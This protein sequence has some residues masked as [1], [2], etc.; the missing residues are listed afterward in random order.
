MKAVVA[1]MLFAGHDYVAGQRIVINLSGYDWKLTLDPDAEW[2]KDKLYA[3][4]V[5]I[6]TLPVNLPVGGWKALEKHKGV[7]VHL[8]ATVEQYFWGYNGETFGVTGN[9]IGVS[10]FVT[11]VVIPDEMK[12][13]RIALHTESVRLRAEIFV[14]GQLA[15][16]DLVSGTPFET[17]ITSFVQ[18]G[19][20]NKIAYRITDPNGNFNWKD[21]QVYAWGDYWMNPTHGFGGITG[22]V[23]LVATDRIYVDDVFVKNKPKVDEIDTQIT[24]MNLTGNPVSGKL[25]IRINEA[26][27]A[28]KTVYAKEVN[29]S[30]NPG[31]NQQTVTVR[32]PNAKLWSVE[33]PNLYILDASWKSAEAADTYQQQFGFRWF[34]VRDNKGDK[35]YYLNGKRIVLLSAI[36][37]GFWP[38]NGIAPS[39]ELAKKQVAAAK[40]LGM[41][42]LNF[43]RAIGQRK[44]LNAAD[45]AGLLYWQE[46]G[47]NSYP[48]NRF[49]AQDTLGKM[50]TD[51]YFATRT[52]KLLRMIKRDRSHPSLIIY[53]MHNERGAPPQ[54]QDYAQMRA[55]HRLDETR[56][57]IYNSCNGENPMDRPDAKFKTHLMPYDT[58]FR[59]YGWYDRHHAGG[60]GV[61]H[62]NLYNSPINYLRYTN[63]KDE[64]VFWGEDG[65]IGTPPRLQLIRDEILKSG[66]TTGWEAADY[67]HWYDAYN[68]FLKT[69]GFDNAFPDVD[70]LTTA[71]GNVSYY[72]QGRIIENIRINNINDGYAINGWESMKWENHSGI[73][74]NY[75]NLKGNP[76]LI[77]RYNRPLYVAVKTNWKVL[78]AGDT[79]T[80]DFFI[81]NEKDVKGKYMLR[82][83]LTDKDDQKITTAE[84]P[85]TVTGGTVYGELLHAGWKIPVNSEGYFTVKAELLK[86][87]ETVCDGDEQLFAVKMDFSGVTTDGMIADASGALSN[88]MKSFG[89]HLS[90]Y[91][92]GTPVGKYLL[93]GDFDPP[94]SQWG[95][96]ISEIM[97]W[98]YTGN[99]LIIVGNPGRWGEF[100][101]DKEVLDYRGS[102]ILGTS[103]YG[104]NFFAKEH[105][106]LTGLPI[107]CAFNW[108]YQCF[109]T[110]NR[111][112][113]GLR[114]FNGETVVACVSDHKK[115]VYSALSVIPAGRGVVILCSLDILACI[116]DIKPLLQ[117]IDIDGANASINTFNTSSRNRANIVGQQ[118]LLN[119]LKWNQ[120]SIINRTK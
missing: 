47:G 115:E 17:D 19:K 34:E 73:V 110:Y 117:E 48:I 8:P 80:V 107:N 77:A 113:I 118:L 108:E 111:Q 50:Q 112:R 57:L 1:I 36:S 103:W 70:A 119:M 59:N 15:G 66:R 81:V 79:A 2:K 43:H 98:V 71:M 39:E 105:P 13:K 28:E 42:M 87:K 96:G 29:I 35:Q 31:E 69:S 5:D 92:G 114:N 20:E 24:L 91:R 76:D 84:W 85:V 49:N 109:A 6:R 62:D 97:E 40:T 100:L 74:D 120:E 61:Y 89:F 44:V 54:A 86:G 21:S 82:A 12:G 3:P 45:E 90:E 41:N 106:L 33:S 37:W 95:S 67:L 53:N 10:W 88:F 18:F 51:F 83:S 16:Y 65:A 55:G 11:S 94:Q 63:H 9:Y 58:V 7:T 14:N 102:K 23:H 27:N 72:Y 52:E 116:K 104:G 68:N 32:L 64:V 30:L 99:K 93:V 26:K 56:I 101:A 60:P 75:R 22:E 78:A 4:P 46:P 38:D 25:T